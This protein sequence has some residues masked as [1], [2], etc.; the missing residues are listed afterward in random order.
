MAA[1]ESYAAIESTDVLSIAALVALVAALCVYSYLYSWWRERAGVAVVGLI[2]SAAMFVIPIMLG[3]LLDEE[4]DNSP[5]FPWVEVGALALGL[6]A[7]LLS[8]YAMIR[9]KIR[10][11]RR[12]SAL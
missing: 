12:K 1:A 11:D 3:H 5:V 8:I 9:A 6:T 4:T 10:A 2:V 7:A